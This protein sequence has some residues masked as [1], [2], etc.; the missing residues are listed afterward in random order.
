MSSIVHFS[1]GMVCPLALSLGILI[2]LS[3]RLVPR[4]R[5]TLKT[6]QRF[7]ACM[8]LV[9]NTLPR[10]SPELSCEFVVLL[11]LAPLYRA[12]HHEYIPAF[13]RIA[14]GLA[15]RKDGA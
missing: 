1:A 14:L 7:L 3:Y 5:I 9:K 4:C 8:R 15:E 13:P 2:L 11:E 10:L 6:R 12:I